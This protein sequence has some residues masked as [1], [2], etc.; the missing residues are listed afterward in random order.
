MARAP[1]GRTSPRAGSRSAAISTVPTLI[2]ET[3]T[4]VQLLGYANARQPDSDSV[5]TWEVAG[6]SHADAHLI[7][8]L[9]GGPRDPNVGGLLGCTEPINTGPHHEVIQAAL[10]HLVGWTAGGEPPPKAQRI[11]LEKGE[12]VIIARDEHGIAHRR[13][14]Q[15]TRGRPDRRHHR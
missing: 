4:D 15:S 2:F 14:A 13:R 5:R 10:H 11:E 6:T 9:I 12:K 3:E 8:A 7:R 1:G